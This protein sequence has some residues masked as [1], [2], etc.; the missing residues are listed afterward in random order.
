MRSVNVISAVAKNNRL[1][2]RGKHVSSTK[3][4][5]GA[6]AIVVALM[7]TVFLAFAAL[8]VDVVRLHVVRNELQNAADAAALAGAACLYAHSAC[9]NVSAKGPDWTT[10]PN[11]ATSA[12]SLNSAVNV[13]LKNATV[14]YGYWDIANPVNGLQSSS[15]KPTSTSAPAVSVT[16]SESNGS[17]SG[18]I[19]TFFGKFAGV[20]AVPVSA[21]AVAVVSQPGYVGP[22]GLFP[23]A[24]TQCMFD[25]Y[26]DSTNNKP[27]TAT[28]TS[29]LPGQSLNQ[30]VGQPYVFQIDSSYHAG[31][32]DS[33]QWT[34]F[35]TADNNVPD[36]RS[37]IPNGFSGTLGINQSPG[38]YIVPGTKT[39]L[40]GAVD[41]CSAEGDK[42]CEYVMV[43]VVPALTAKTFQNVVAFACLHIDLAV[44]GSGKYIQAEMS[45]NPDKCEGVGSSG[46]GT[47]YGAITP[48]RLVY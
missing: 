27:K 34:T 8:A 20:S 39:T 48:A 22:G 23:V 6:I 17:N 41:S 24:I 26:W 29:P 15:S 46:I 36:V 25:N 7:L 16:V 18:A 37:L 32:C 19:Q 45:N 42:T 38:T 2:Q 9:G 47:G 11:E 28:S 12:I 14:N 44:G 35:T 3:R 30:V 5:R 40:Y 10:A 21:T 43:P 13:K 33:G 4:Q 31:P 1:Q